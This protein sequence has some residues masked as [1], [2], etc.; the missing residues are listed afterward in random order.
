[1]DLQNVQ[2]KLDTRERLK[3]RCTESSLYR[4]SLKGFTKPSGTN[5]G[6]IYREFV[7]S[8]VRIIERLLYY[9]SA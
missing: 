6:S 7:L 5:L 2:W 8:G 9:D 1:M 3:V 4:V